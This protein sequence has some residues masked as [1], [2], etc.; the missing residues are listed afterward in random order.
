MDKKKGISAFLQVSVVMLI[1]LLV[2]AGI[3]YVIFSQINVLQIIEE[4]IYNYYSNRLNQSAYKLEKTM[5]DK[6]SSPEAI[7]PF[8]EELESEYWSAKTDGK[9]L[10]IKQDTVVNLVNLI[11][12]IDAS[13]CFILLNA[14]MA[15]GSGEDQLYYIHD[16]NEWFTSR[17][18][19]DLILEVGEYEF[20]SE[21]GIALGAKWKP[22]ITKGEYEEI[23]AIKEDMLK[24]Y[25]E[26]E[27]KEASR[28]AY[29]KGNQDLL[30]KGHN[31][32]IYVRPIIDK[33]SKKIYGILGI[34]V[35]KDL[36]VDIVESSYLNA[37]YPAAFA[38]V[39]DLGDGKL[40]VG[41]ATIEAYC[42]DQIDNL[43]SGKEISYFKEV[44]KYFD[45]TKGYEE[46][47]FY[48]LKRSK[49]NSPK[50][51]G[52]EN[53]LK[54]YNKNSYNKKDN[55]K[56]ILLLDARNIHYNSNDYNKGIIV[57]I[58]MSIVTA[59]ILTIVVS[60]ILTKQISNMV[61]E[62]ENMDESGR[63][64]FSD[65]STK[66]I[67]LLKNKIVEMS[68]DL[69]HTYLQMQNLLEITGNGIVIF[70]ENPKDKTFT[71]TGRI[72]ILLQNPDPSEQAIQKYSKREFGNMIRP[73]IRDYRISFA[74]LENTEDG[75]KVMKVSARKPLK[76]P[77]FY[78][79]YVRKVV[80]SRIFHVY[81]DYTKEYL[82]M[83][84]L[85]Y[86]KNYDPL[87]NLLNRSY[88]KK[89][90]EDRLKTNPSQK[91]VMLMWD[92]DN[93]K[94]INDIYGH[95]WG[96]E[97]LRETAAIISL[98]TAEKAFVSRFA[99]DEFF[100]F[101]NYSGDKE[102]VREKVRSIQDKLL[103]SELMIA[104][105][106]KV[107]I[108][109]SVGIC[110]YPDDASNYDELY[111]YADFAMYGAK[112]SNKGS[113]NEFD[114]DLYEKEYIVL[115]AKEELNDLIEKKA[116]NFA[117]QPII[118]CQTGEVYGYEALMRPISEVLETVSDVMRVAKP[119]FKLAQIEQLTFESVLEAMEKK[120]VF[121]G[122]KKIF[123]NSIASKTLP[124]ESEKIIL[125]KFKKYGQKIV[126]EITE[127]E[128]INDKTMAVKQGYKKDYSCMIAVDDFGAGYSSDKTLLKIKPDFIKIDMHLIRNIQ[129]DKEKQQRVA[130]LID[131]RS[132]NDAKIIAEG[133]ESQEELDYLMSIG[134]DYIQGFYLCKP[135]FQICDISDKKKAEILALG[136]KWIEKDKF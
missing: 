58:L 124:E 109:A 63:I 95:D 50:I 98:F 62:I 9:E 104:D 129:D 36:L 14:E 38:I 61:E 71:R 29:W 115:S 126:I 22:S 100:V 3:F 54:I 37:E 12:N 16:T 83:L 136:K 25:N 64:K 8:M 88:F 31:S 48:V 130:N 91:C 15:E 121:I 102:E 32:F 75:T 131:Y 13:G 57:S 113:I 66:E 96:D 128:E 72:S 47:F 82:D 97:Y 19:S 41:S 4:S 68:E 46:S 33:Y 111:K 2:Q 27:V 84:K 59:I 55:W 45:K 23:Y 65:T 132:I 53:K 92:L 79:K 112:H 122:D 69:A 35:R 119:Q 94:F 30:E 74:D 123:I 101:F 76:Y 133:I 70:E 40:D 108:R 107:K 89:C 125:E 103:G 80:D 134:V 21:L 26:V 11:K 118:S 34:E 106:E 93:L 52:I 43:D 78:L 73:M 120:S 49:D 85:V 105:D 5:V 99:G 90:V 114:R 86:E 7:D 87:T 18:N 117:F 24:R 81:T 77:T 56:I 39:K 1:V 20:A 6:W 10:K 42:G 110:W 28:L 60:S 44:N 51:Y 127:A 135:E 17:S 67:N 116:V